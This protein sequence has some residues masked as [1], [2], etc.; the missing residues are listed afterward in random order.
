[1]AD[2]Q[3]ALDTLAQMEIRLVQQMYDHADLM[4]LARLKYLA[5]EPQ[6]DV[7]NLQIANLTRRLNQRFPQ[8][9]PVTGSPGTTP[10]PQPTNPAPTS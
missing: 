5:R 10:T 4:L 9:Q 6:T 3:E 1:M 8:P 7:I 2:P